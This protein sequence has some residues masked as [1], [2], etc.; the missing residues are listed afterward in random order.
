MKTDHRGFEARR[1]GV[2]CAALFTIVGVSLDTG[3]HYR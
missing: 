3:S 1:D 2:P